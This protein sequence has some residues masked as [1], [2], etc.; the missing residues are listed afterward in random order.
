MSGSELHPRF[1]SCIVQSWLSNFVDIK[2]RVKDLLS[3]IKKNVNFLK[4]LITINIEQFFLVKK[5]LS[6][7][8]EY[9]A[10]CLFVLVDIVYLWK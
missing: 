6:P 8:E 5:I 7:Q 3:E 1:T 4:K 2:N 9:I 10:E